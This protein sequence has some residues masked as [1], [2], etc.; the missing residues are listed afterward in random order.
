LE[1]TWELYNQNGTGEKKKE[2]KTNCL[3]G[4]GGGEPNL[5][6]KKKFKGIAEFGKK[7][8]LGGTGVNGGKDPT[9]SA[10]GKLGVNKNQDAGE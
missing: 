5:S 2:N 3:W 1:T 10:T 7:R 8:L 6:K 9:Q 4:N